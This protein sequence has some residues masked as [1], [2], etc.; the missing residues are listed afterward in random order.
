MLDEWVGSAAGVLVVTHDQRL[1]ERA[2]HV[3]RLGDEPAA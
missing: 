2:E 3:I 1:V